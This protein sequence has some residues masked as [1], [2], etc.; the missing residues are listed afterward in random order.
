MAESKSDLQSSRRQAKKP[1]RQILLE[2]ITEGQH[3]LE[4]PPLGLFLS[5]ISAGLDIGF[6]L[7]LM[8]VMK[9]LIDHRLS[10]PIS[11]L[12]I[13]N[14][15]AVGF[16]FV[17]LGRSELFTEHTTLAVLPLL[18]G[19]SSLGSV[20]QLWGIV[21][22]GN[23][24]GAAAFAALTALIGPALHVIDPAALGSIARNMLDHPAGAILLSGILA[25]WLMG[26]MSW[27]VTAARDTISQIV[28]VWIIATSIGLA[29][30]HHAVVGTVEVLAGAFC[31]QGISSLD[32]AHF[33]LWTTLGNAIGGT[34]FVGLLKY[35]H[36]S[37]GENSSG[38]HSKSL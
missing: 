37:R 8:A 9:T 31:G 34:V 4:R 26:L 11:H 23:M 24:L 30:L 3:E 13:A 7:F 19:R 18:S 33:L 2:E 16:V 29:Q 36:A 10:E 20:A 1:Y 12:L 27:L 28:I 21:Y 22:V 15:Y 14:M 6:S 17:V 5:A 35:S 25:A 32:F 38:G